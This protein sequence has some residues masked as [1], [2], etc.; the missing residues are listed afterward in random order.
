MG[1]IGCMG[2]M[3]CMG[4]EIR[5][6]GCRICIKKIPYF[7]LHCTSS[8]GDKRAVTVESGVTMVLDVN[9]DMDMPR[10]FLLLACCP[11]RQWIQKKKDK[12]RESARPYM[13][14]R[15]AHL[16]FEPGQPFL[17]QVQRQG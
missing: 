2:C 6:R 9:M 13:G 7:Y 11:N 4:V 10:G 12:L 17:V 15:N 14:T 3:C 16:L 5:R 8:Y 1:C